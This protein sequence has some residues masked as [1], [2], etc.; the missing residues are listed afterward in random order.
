MYRKSGLGLCK[1]ETGILIEY[2]EKII[3][4]GRHPGRVAVYK[5]KNDH[6]EKKY[7]T[8]NLMP[9]R[10]SHTAVMCPERPNAYFQNREWKFPARRETFPAHQRGDA[11]C[12][13][14][15]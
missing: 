14:P 15:P 8:Q 12:P 10:M 3:E 2:W 1:A 9:G 6:I 7:E 13:Y 5:Q 4:A 11:F